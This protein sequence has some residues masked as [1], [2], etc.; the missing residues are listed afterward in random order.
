MKPTLFLLGPS[1]LDA[2]NTV[3]RESVGQGMSRV[4]FS[5]AGI[6]PILPFI[7]ED[8]TLS[9][10]SRSAILGLHRIQRPIRGDLNVFNLVGDADSSP[11]ML[12]QVQS[13]VDQLRPSRCFNPPGNVLKT[14][15]ATL[16][17]T[18]AGM[19]GCIVPRVEAAQPRDFS[20]L[21]ALCRNFDHWPLIV[22][23][24]GEHGGQQLV[25]LEDIRQLE[26]HRAT[27]WLYEGICLI[28]YHDYR[29]DDGLYQKNRVIVIEGV[30]YPRH[31]LFSRHWM[32]HAGSRAELMTREIA[33]VR[34]EERFIA[35]EVQ[36]YSPVF[37]EMHRRIG[38]DVFGVDFAVKDG[39]VLVF[40]ANAC[41][42]FLDRTHRADSRMSYLDGHVKTLKRALKKMLMRA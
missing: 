42:K 18:L 8:K 23:S 4:E 36:A 25:L 5:L 30:P 17:A 16:P 33:L 2:Q 40:E 35:T 13:V 15:R 31:A 9:A 39:R 26:E 12:R 37:E 29:G 21:E 11:N 27:P 32:V 1:D 38:L 19:A 14:A 10:N 34:R 24:R 22:R 41:M 20:E 28:E 3:A 7:D 6:L